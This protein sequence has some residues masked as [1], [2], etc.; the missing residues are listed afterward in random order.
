MES[1]S[2]FLEVI[3]NQMGGWPVLARSQNNFTLFE[4][5]V[6]LRKMGLN[7]LID[8]YVDF[9]PKDPQTFILKVILNDKIYS[10]DFII[11]NRPKLN[12]SIYTSIGPDYLIILQTYLKFL[13]F[14]AL[15]IYLV[16]KLNLTWLVSTTIFF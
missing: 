5:M 16:I 7:S 10:Y 6:K 4:I 2:K 8:L 3:D 12:L 13:Y 15:M 14:L 1:E 11:L 9:N